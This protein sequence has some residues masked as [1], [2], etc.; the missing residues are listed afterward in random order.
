M[1]KLHFYLAVCFLLFP[2]S[3]TAWAESEVEL[4]PR[5]THSLG[6]AFVLIPGGPF[7]YDYQPP[8]FSD[9]ATPSVIVLSPFRRII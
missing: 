4:A 2:G 7:R 5:W 9:P 6:I 1:I 8:A 3:Q